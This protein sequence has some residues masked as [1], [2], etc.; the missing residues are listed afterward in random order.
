MRKCWVPSYLLTLTLG[1]QK[2]AL[3]VII[4]PNFTSVAVT[5]TQT[6]KEHSEVKGLIRLTTSSY[7]PF[8]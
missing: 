2:A 3:V 6:K 5:N 7:T 4:S 1:K 8:L